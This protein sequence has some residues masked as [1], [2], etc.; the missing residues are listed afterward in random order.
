MEIYF[1][2]YGCTANINSS[3]IMKGL[4]KQAG[5][6]ITLNPDFADLIVLNSCIVKSST[7]EK[8]RRRI[9]DLLKQGKRILLAG[10]MPR[11]NKEKLQHENLYLLDTSQV[12]NLINLIKDI[13][14]NDYDSERYLFHRNEIK[15][16]LPKISNEKIIGITQIS[17]GCLGKCTYCIVRLAKGKLFSYPQEKIIESIKRDINAGAKEI[18]ITSQDNASYGNEEGKY[19]LPDLLKNILKIKGNFIIRI[20]MMNPNNV[21]KILPELI[22]IYKNSKIFKFLHLPIQSGSD[23]VLKDMKREYK[24]NDAL[25]IIKE[26]KKQIPEITIATDIIVGYPTETEKD[27]KKTLEIIK[28]INPEILNRSNFAPRPKTPA[29]KLKQINPE[30]M[31]ARSKKLMNLHLQICKKNQKNWIGNEIKVLV[32]KKGWDNTW[33]GRTENY[34]LAVVLSDKNIL[35]KFIKVKVIKINPHYL[36][37]KPKKNI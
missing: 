21:L 25:K 30:I 4:V 36:I 6:N 35:G 9:Q 32:D 5:L 34:K 13:K 22:D 10:C 8:I 11:L 24:I 3:E 20:G 14:D 23:K 26:F 17:E 33:L 1:E 2:T 7:Q 27:F 16:G 28:E 19:L 12:K 29:E 37:C 15:A 18:W 31:R